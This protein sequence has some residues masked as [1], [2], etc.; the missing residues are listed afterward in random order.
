M[1]NLVPEKALNFNVYTET[2]ELLRIAEGTMPNVEMMTSEVKGAGI[3]GVVD[4]PGMGQVNSVTCELTWR[5]RTKSWATLLAPV[6][7]ILDMYSAE[8]DFDAGLG[9]YVTRQVHLFMRAVT[10][11]FDMG[12]LAVNESTETKTTHEVYQM[13]LDID[14][15]EQLM[16]DK[17]NY[18]YRVKG[19]DFM[20][21]VRSALGK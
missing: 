17:Y 18:I 3:A 2:G 4:S 16:I 21:G 1:P 6:G 12:K 13:K 5:T 19:I 10:K 14:G 15:I 9:I 8:I 11:S 20:T 7:H